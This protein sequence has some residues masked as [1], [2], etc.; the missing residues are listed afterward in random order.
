MAKAGDEISPDR[1]TE[2]LSEIARLRQ[3]VGFLEVKGRSGDVIVIDGV[4]RA[5]LP[6]G[7]KLRISMGKIAVQVLRDGVS[8]LDREVEVF[9]NGTVTVKVD[10]EEQTPTP[11]VTPEILEEVEPRSTVVEDTKRKRSRVWTW[12]AFGI[13][14]AAAIGAGVTG[15]IALSKRADIDDQCTD[16]VCPANLE[17]DEDGVFALSLTT[18]ILI[19][20]GAVGL[21]AGLLLYFY[22]LKW[23]SS[24]EIVAAPAIG[25]NHAGLIISGRF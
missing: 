3:M 15:G 2:V 17:D 4:E 9:G 6:E 12:V 8:I 22:E 11:T 20:I 19:G 13:G 21:G 10:V 5:T 25:E 18:D 14:G 24:E 16:N 23:F 1:Q 7:A